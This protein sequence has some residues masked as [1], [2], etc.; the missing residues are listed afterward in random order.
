MN[1]P[2][3]LPMG[4]LLVLGGL[5]PTLLLLATSYL[6]LS[7]VLAS[8]R[9]AFGGAQVPGT[10]AVAGLSA[11]LTVLV[12]TP[13]AERIEASAGPAITEAMPLDPLSPA[14][15]EA[16][17]RAW[18]LARSPIARFLRDNATPADRA[19]FV[20][21]AR[22]ARTRQGVAAAYDADDLRVLLPA[23]VVSE[24]VR[25]M[26]IA[27]LLLLPFLVVDLV[28][29]NML[30]ATGLQSLSPQAVALPL[31]LLLFVLA[32]GWHLLAR[33]LVLSYR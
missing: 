1:A 11:L 9:S 24:L 6:K 14:G 5:L 4:V 7:L 3:A 20:D 32:D 17:Q 21:L 25:A 27:F 15:R 29:A 12:M 23:F 30:V 33:A 19:F 16:W 10:L 28:V 13:T 31:K 22:R 8:L 18:T 2:H 26:V